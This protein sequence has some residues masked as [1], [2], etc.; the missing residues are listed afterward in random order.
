[1]ER[2][3]N[4]SVPLARRI[5]RHLNAG[6]QPTISGR[7]VVLQDVILVRASGQEAPAAEELRRQAAARGNPVDI[8]YWNRAAEVERQGN[9]IYGF[10]LSG[11]RHLIAQRRN[12]QRVVTAAGRRFYEEMPQTN[13]IIHLPVI[14]RRTRPNFPYSFLI[15]TSLT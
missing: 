11:N 14:H 10:D 3:P 6:I 2:A 9:R 12:N 8:S 15:P 5:T 4:V 13:W 1:M 7:K